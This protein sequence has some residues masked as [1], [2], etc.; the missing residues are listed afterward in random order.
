MNDKSRQ[1]KD[2]VDLSPELN[3][4]GPPPQALSS[5]R[6]CS[7]IGGADFRSTLIHL[8]YRYLGKFADIN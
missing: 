8:N 5:L 3:M 7:G 6:R 4:Q 2:P 1:L